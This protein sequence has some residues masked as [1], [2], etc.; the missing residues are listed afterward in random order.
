[1]LGP[2]LK[3]QIWFCV[4]GAR[5]SAPCQKWVKREGFVAFPKT[6]AGA[7]H[8]QRI[9][10]DA[11]RVAG[12]VHETC[13]SEMLGGQDAGFLRG[14][15]FWRIR[16]SILGRW[17]CVT[18]AALRMTWHQF[19][20]AGAITLETQKRIGTRPSALHSTFHFEGHLAELLCF[21]CCQLGKLRKSPRIASLLML[22][23][24]KLEEVSQNVAFLVLSSFKK[25][26]SRR[27]ASFSSL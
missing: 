25:S 15:A 9:C 18:G 7:G 12:A 10:K 19:S 8:L 6:M 24:S 11:C 26:K 3:V 21:W 23:S 27:T 14:V 22:S 1:M 20:V 16:S 17:F 5:D 4:A 2:L 13:S